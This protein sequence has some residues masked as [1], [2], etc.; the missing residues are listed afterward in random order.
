MELALIAFDGLDPRVIYEHREELPNIDSVLETGMHG[1]WSTPGHTIPS[2]TATLTGKQYNEVNFHWDDGG[3]NYQRHRQ[4]PYEFLWEVV[5]ASMSLLNMPT[6]YPPEEIDDAMVCGFLT[7]D[8]AVENNL[9][10]PYIVQDILN[11]MDYIHDVHADNTYEELGGERMLDHMKYIMRTRIEAAEMLI[12][13]FD[14]DLFYGAWTSTDRWFHQ[15]Q[16]HGEDFLPLYKEAD[17]VVGEMLDILPDDIPVVFFSDHGFA[18]F[19]HDDGVHK[20]HMYDGWYAV[21]NADVPAYRDDSMSIFDLFPTVVNYLGGDVPDGCVGRT[22]FHSEEDN[23]SI[24]DR[25]GDLGY[26]E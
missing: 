6:L 14:S 25:L 7:P 2:F 21:H 4:V 22:M 12:E 13:E 23:Q 9:A 24:K 5:D 1:E 11:E 17:D 26:L 20:G 16:K 8:S 3:G 10:R 15:C 19:P 18:H